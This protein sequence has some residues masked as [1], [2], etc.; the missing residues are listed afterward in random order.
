M[1]SL[2]FLEIREP[3]ASRFW[4]M[5]RCAAHYVHGKSEL[6]GIESVHLITIKAIVHG[7]YSKSNHTMKKKSR[8]IKTPAIASSPNGTTCSIAEARFLTIG[9]VKQWVMIRSHDMIQNP[10]LVM[11]H[12]GPGISETALW[13]FY[14]SSDLEKHFVVVYWDQRGSGKSYDKNNLPSKESM[15][16]DQ[17]TADLDQ[18]VDY[19]CKRCNQHSQKVA[20]FGHSWGSV[21]GPLYAKRYP[22]KVLA[23]IGCGQIGDWAASEQLTYTYVLQEAERRHL[24][25]A[26]RDLKRIGPP[27]HDC[28]ALCTQRNWL[29]HLD[30]D[31]SVCA[32]LQLMRVHVSVPETSLSDLFCFYDILKFSISAMWSGVTKIN[33]MEAVPRLDM[34]TFFLLGKQDHCVPNEISLEFI[35][36]LVAPSKQVIWF[37]FSEHLA[38]VDEAQKFN[39]TMITKVRPVVM[40]QFQMMK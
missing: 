29:A 10:I 26:V 39:E 40:E 19:C 7:S 3:F 25:R 16:V 31:T 32:I 15:T 27:P 22:D 1:V 33:L 6:V 28:Q 8:C 11:L 2:L 36:H 5:L 4:D 13:R 35:S 9:G 18:V 30:G 17:F 20:L 14:N 21:L 37:E 38:F 12:G 23:Y 24:H 34:P